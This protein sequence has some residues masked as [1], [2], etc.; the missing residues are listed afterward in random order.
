MDERQKIDK[1]REALNALLDKGIKFEIP[2]RKMFGRERKP[3][4]FTIRQPYLGTMDHLAELFLEMNMNEDLIK[5]DP[6]AQSRKLAY[7]NSRRMSRVVA[8]AVLNSYW[9]IKLFSGILSRYFR[10]KITPSRL[11][12][13]TMI[14]NTISNVGDF[15][16][17]IRLLSIVRTTEPKADRI[18]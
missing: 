6:L 16:N 5:A 18:E 8:I 1:E 11:F 17:S 3:R 14:I 7:E 9:R 4:Y 15:T 10:W 13:L 2:R 12:Q